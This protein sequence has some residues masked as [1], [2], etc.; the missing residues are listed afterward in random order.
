MG[1][2]VR[3]VGLFLDSMSSAAAPG[4]QFEPP[5]DPPAT[6]WE[7]AVIDGAAGVSPLLPTRV[8]WAPTVGGPIARDVQ[9]KCA[10]AASLLAKSCGAELAEAS[11][12]LSKASWAFTV[13]RGQAFA[14]S[15]EGKKGLKPEIMWNAQIGNSCSGD[16][17]EEA[18]EAHKQ[19]HEATQRFFAEEPT[20]LVVPGG[21]VSG[22]DAKIRY[23]QSIAGNPLSNYLEWMRP[24]CVITMTGCPAISVPVGISDCGLPIGVQ[25]VG[26]EGADAAVLAAA[27]L[28]EAALKLPAASDKLTVGTS[29]LEADG[30]RTAEDALA[31]HTKCD[32]QVYLKSL[33]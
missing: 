28:L 20:I 27:G 14:K 11:P 9:L 5:E 10:A 26:P 23:P 19:I 2:C 18:R 25:L 17:I 8:A 15:F 21:A 6:G 7:Q 1:R 24:L 30:P 29:E 22:F 16:Q 32:P 33:L 3:D 12:D 13:L 31:H 4:W